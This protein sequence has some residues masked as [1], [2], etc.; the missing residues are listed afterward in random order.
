MIELPLNKSRG[1]V[2]LDEELKFDIADL[3]KTNKALIEILESQDVDIYQASEAILEHSV[4]ENNNNATTDGLAVLE[5]KQAE[6][7]VSDKH[8]IK[9]QIFA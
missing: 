9:M 8:Q 3:V 2:R 7:S 1:L 4:S 5:N 6:I